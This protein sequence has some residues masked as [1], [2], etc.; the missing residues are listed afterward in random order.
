MNLLAASDDALEQNKNEDGQLQN[1]IKDLTTKHET[2]VAFAR[3]HATGEWRPTLTEHLT[4][5]FRSVGFTMTRH[6]RMLLLYLP[7]VSQVLTKTTW[8]MSLEVSIEVLK[9]S[10]CTLWTGWILFSLTSFG[11]HSSI[12]LK[13]SS[14]RL[15]VTAFVELFCY[16]LR[17]IP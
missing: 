14:L 1:T 15:Q 7:S 17:P 4:V 8:R 11:D 12:I 10:K 3:K 5:H 9:C 13:P 16:F 2:A 6:R